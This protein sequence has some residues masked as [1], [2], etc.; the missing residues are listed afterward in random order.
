MNKHSQC[1]KVISFSTNSCFI[2]EQHF[3]TKQRKQTF[4]KEIKPIETNKNFS[5]VQKQ[6]DLNPFER[7]VQQHFY[8]TNSRMNSS[9]L[10]LDS[11]LRH[12]LNL[13]ISRSSLK[14]R[15]EQVVASLNFYISEIKTVLVWSWVGLRV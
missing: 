12:N 5:D 1:L 8:R 10:E 9:C 2:L 7:S 14:N 6:F 3:T 11:C 4:V 15:Q 13:F